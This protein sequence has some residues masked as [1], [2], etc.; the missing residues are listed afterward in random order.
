MSH[1]TCM[2]F[3]P[4]GLIVYTPL[5][6][7]PSWESRAQ[8]LGSPGWQKIWFEWY[9]WTIVKVVYFYLVM[10]VVFLLIM[11]DYYVCKIPTTTTITTTKEIYWEE[12]FI[13]KYRS[14]VHLVLELWKHYCAAFLCF[15][16]ALL[17][18]L[19]FP[20][21][22]GLSRVTILANAS[23]TVGSNVYDADFVL[24]TIWLILF[25]YALIVNNNNNDNNISES[26]KI[27]N[28]DDNISMMP[29]IILVMMMM[30]LLLLTIV[31]RSRGG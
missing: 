4:S 15:F 9:A 14:C 20:L 18:S 2:A 5:D 27:Y 23:C 3:P 30:S 12:G 25:A 11:N 17:L 6:V 16:F 13:N 7:T 19:L 24:A 26:N 1:N 21:T 28:D 22:T 31:Y 10:G 8:L 29:T